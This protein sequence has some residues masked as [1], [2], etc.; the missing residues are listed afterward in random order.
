ML[1]IVF[2]ALNVNITHAE[3]YSTTKIAVK[4][5]QTYLSPF[6]NSTV[7]SRMESGSKFK[8]DNLKIMI[9]VS[10]VIFKLF[11]RF[12]NSKCILSKPFARSILAS[13]DN[14]ELQAII[15]KCHISSRRLRLWM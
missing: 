14:R 13:I 11:V 12:K 3:E 5:V 8:L 2:Y 7:Y 1:N 6:F 9:P 4:L 15:K 10:S